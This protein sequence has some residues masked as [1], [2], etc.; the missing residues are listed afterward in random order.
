MVGRTL[1]VSPSY[2]PPPP[3]DLNG[4]EIFNCACLFSTIDH[5]YDEQSIRHHVQTFVV[6]ID[7]FKRKQLRLQCI[8]CPMILHLNVF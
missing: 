5:I 3:H 8:L 7:L 1:R 4:N 2:K 6:S